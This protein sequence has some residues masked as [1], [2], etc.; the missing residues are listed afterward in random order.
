MKYAVM[1]F[2]LPCV[3]VCNNGEDRVYLGYFPFDKLI[4]YYF[5]SLIIFMGFCLWVNDL[6]SLFDSWY[7][8]ASLMHLT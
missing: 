5:S 7:S 3:L 2:I 1:S 4:V 6:E 8:E